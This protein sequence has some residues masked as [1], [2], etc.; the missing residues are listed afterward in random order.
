[1]SQGRELDIT[2]LIGLKWSD[3]RR[4]A[5]D[6]VSETGPDALD[7]AVQ[8]Y[9]HPAWE[10][11]AFA[12]QMLGS[13]AATDLRALAFLSEQCGSDPAWQVNEALAM[14]FDDYCSATG[15]EQALPAMRDWLR[16]SSPNVR[17]AVSEGLRPWTSSKRPYFARDP[18][19]AIDMLGTL[20]DDDSRYVQ[21]S[22][23]NALRDISRKHFDLVL[24]ALRAW[25]AE[26]PA[27]RPRRT[28]ARFALES[29]VKQD[30]SLRQIYMAAVDNGH[31]Q[32]NN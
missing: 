12:V 7:F 5:K 4:E 27:S 25:L 9:S 17:R 23:G 15:Y 21:E 19:A 32:G 28:I 14:A 3:I 24:T 10:V 26:N 30:P 31:D 8:S 2:H 20:K 13:L 18:V 16:S 1:M 11:R 29:A 22:V 6:C